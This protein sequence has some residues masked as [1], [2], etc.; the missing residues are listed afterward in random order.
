MRYLHA[1]FAFTPSQKSPLRLWQSGRLKKYS[2]A[3][4]FFLGA[5]GNFFFAF[6][7]SDATCA[8]LDFIV[9]FAHI[10]FLVRSLL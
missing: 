7:G 5:F 3:L 6:V 10:S 4:G 8:F 1:L 9:L 2:A